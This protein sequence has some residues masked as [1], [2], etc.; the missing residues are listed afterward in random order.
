MNSYKN[1]G[2]YIHIPFCKSKCGYCDFFSITDQSYKNEFLKYLLSEIKMYSTTAQKNQLFDTIYIGGGTPSLLAL[3]NLQSIIDGLNHTFS[4]SDNVEVTL[5]VNPGTV[6]LEKFKNFKRAGINRLSIGIQSFN[7]FELEILERIHNA[8]EAVK[9]YNMSREAGFDNINID[10]IYALPEQNLQQWKENICRAIQLHPEH[11]SAYNLTYEKNTRFFLLN[12]FG[13]LNSHTE[14]VGE[15]F[16]NCTHDI[17]ETAGYIHYEISNFAI[18]DDYISKH[19]LKY[20]KHI[21]YLGFGPSAHSFQNNQ[22]WGNVCSVKDYISIL[23]KNKRPIQFEET[24]SLK[25]KIFEYIFLGLRTYNGIDLKDFEQQFAINF[26]KIY[27]NILTPLLNGNH[28]V[29]NNE[30]FKLTKKGMVI[31]D[32][33]LPSFAS[34]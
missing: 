19:N 4:I 15:E 33:I 9:C 10:L 32:E 20:W 5:E 6:D 27:K 7:D 17:L 14:K 22:R 34:V 18:S 26:L 16:F 3:E 13:Y 2:I 23:K 31:C 30:C 11:I 24:L 21:P 8:G 28:A 25:E 29:L 12:K 1:S